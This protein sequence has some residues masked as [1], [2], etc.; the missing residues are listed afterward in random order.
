MFTYFTWWIAWAMLG[1]ATIG[2]VVL[3]RTR[4]QGMRP[5]KKCALLSLWVHVLLACLA[6][7]VQIFSGSPGIGPEPPIRVTLLPMEVQ[8]ATLD[9]SEDQVAKLHPQEPLQVTPEQAP[10]PEQSQEPDTEEQRA[11]K[12]MSEATIEA[13][14]PAPLQS[15][16]TSEPVPD[17]EA[18]PL[19]EPV[20]PPNEPDP[21]IE[22]DSTSDPEDRAIESSEPTAEP[23]MSTAELGLS[24][25]EHEQSMQT[26]SQQAE[27]P[28]DDLQ[29]PLAIDSSTPSLPA[30][31]TA[32][33]SSQADSSPTPISHP[34]TYHPKYAD[35]FAEKRVQLVTQRGGNEHTERAVRSALAWLAGAQSDTGRWH[36]AHHGAGQEH[37]VLGHNRLGAGAHADTGISGLALL[38]FLGSGQT[39]RHGAYAKQV[40]AGLD[41][42]RRQQSPRGALYGNAQLFARTYCHSMATFA[43]CEA[44][45]LVEDPQLASCAQAATAYSLQIQ[46]GNTGGWRYRPGD[47]GDTSQLGWQLMS[48]QS[49]QVAGIEIPPTTWTRIERFLRLVR[50]GSNGGL[51]AYRP[52]GPTSRTMTA[53]A[54]YCRQLL[55]GQLLDTSQMAAVEEAVG[56]ISAQLPSVANAQPNEER[57]NFYFWYYATLALH[58]TQH[59]SATTQAAWEKWNQALVET[60][61]ATQ[62]SDGSWDQNTV[63]GGYGGRVYTTALAALCLE[64]Y[65]R[66][67]PESPPI[68][69]ARRESWRSVPR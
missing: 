18:V 52:Q 1:M 35:R 34:Q 2:L 42:L 43:I 27:S 56:S 28:H 26:D 11:V 55:A 65:Y 63:W 54:L 53:E 47:V 23:Q 66:Y 30:D 44:Y 67:S 21:V 50:R 6:T 3:L 13:P 39:N 15:I 48:L 37:Q 7:M 36:G 58:R 69:V 68:G 22:S 57:M 25:P 4:W 49:A 60:L 12:D 20:P 41:F 62:Q 64:V 33:P 10:L 32:S 40:A 8:E 31:N 51:A 16:P 9:L 59:L 5:L 46:N 29:P 45:A 38:A 17:G 14:S 61:L 24:Q 19:R